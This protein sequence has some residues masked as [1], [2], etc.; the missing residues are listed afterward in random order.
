MESIN[1]IFSFYDQLIAPLPLHYQGLISL[2]IL[3]FFAWIVYIFIKSKNWIF[4]L[5]IIVL[6][7][8]TWPA[9]R[10]ICLIIW[11]ILKG[12]ASRLKGI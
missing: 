11:N 2:G 9:A 8:E 7:P 4:L 12:L 1:K 10:N 6:L 5:V 3:L